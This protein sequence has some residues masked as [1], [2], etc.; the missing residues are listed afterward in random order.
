MG[1]ALVRL[2]HSYDSQRFMVPAEDVES[3]YPWWLTRE[4]K[5]QG[6]LVLVAERDGVVVGYVYATVE[7]RDWNALLDA[8]GALH[9]IWVDEAARTSG[10]GGCS[11]RISEGVKHLVQRTLSSADWVD[12]LLLLSGLQASTP[13]PQPKAA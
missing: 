1:G 5:R 9:D 11:W 10:V 4:L 13:P 7:G 6:A 3:G 8:H 2:H 12:P